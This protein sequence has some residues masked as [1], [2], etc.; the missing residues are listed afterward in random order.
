MKE[1]RNLKVDLQQRGLTGL[2]L[3]IDE[4]L[5]DTG[6]H[7]WQHMVKFHAPT[8][9]T[10]E[11]VLERYQYIERVPAWQSDAAR[12]YMRQGME[13]NEFQETIPLLHESNT[14]VA[15]LNKVV[16][17]VAYITARPEVVRTGTERWLTA[18]GFPKAPVILRADKLGHDYIATKNQW[19]AEVLRELYPEVLGIVDDNPGLPD[20][21]AKVGYE[22]KLFVYG[23]QMQEIK[24]QDYRFPVIISPTWDHILDHVTS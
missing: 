9:L 22:G 20:E 24:P 10:M 6:P 4:T 3:D 8:G 7:W 15:K 1:A 17:V 23:S 14:M 13:S 12:E 18:H 2:A 21:L 5:S 11:E 19:K 16:P